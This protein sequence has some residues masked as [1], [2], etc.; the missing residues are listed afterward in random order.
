MKMDIEKAINQINEAIK[1]I[2][3]SDI[4]V[5]AVT[6]T[7]PHPRVLEA[8]RCGIK[9]I[10]E[11]RIQEAM[12]KFE[13]MSAEIA[14]NGVKKHFLGHLQSNKAKKAVENFDLIQS[15][16]SLNLA[17]DINKQ[18]SQLNKIQECLIEVKVS[19]EPSKT[20]ISPENVGD[21]YSQALKLPHLL[22]RGLMIIAPLTDDLEGSR[23]YFR[24]GQR[25]FAELKSRDFN[26]LSMGMSSDYKIALQEGAN[27][28]RLGSALFGERQTWK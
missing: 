22:I 18:A 8:I 1:S 10:G 26:I 28:I 11:N 12:P 4:E 20:G 3:V 5:I 27:M 6:K 7:V 21:L 24:Q 14:Q 9:H 13:Q 16:D 19:K 23:P 2:G 15:L 25:L 17:Q